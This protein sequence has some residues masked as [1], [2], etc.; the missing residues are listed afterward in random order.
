[1]SD[2]PTLGLPRELAYLVLLFALFVAPKWLQRYRIP[3]AI[4]S[5]ALGVAATF[6]G[7]F[8]GDPTV[9]LLATFGIVALFLFAGLDIDGDELRRN[10][11]TLV[12]HGLI[13][14]L[15]V[16][17]VAAF[18]Q[19]TFR[20]ALRPAILV[21]LAL[22]TPSTGFILSSLSSFGLDDG[23]RFAVK[24]K[25]VAAELLA[26]GALFFVLQT[27]SVTR[28][29]VASFAM[30]G[31]VLLIPLAFRLFAAT[32][33]PHAPRSEFA[34]LLMVALIC[35]YATRRLGV[36]YLVGA[37]VV[38]VAAQRFRARMP[39]MSSE[40]M[41]EA[42]EAFGSVFIPFYFFSAGTH[43]E[44]RE[45]GLAAVGLGLAFVAAF[46]PLRI[47]VTYAH[48]RW[49]LGDSPAAA[50]R[51]AV[52]LVPTLVFTLVLAEILR[53]RFGASH[54]LVGGL[55]VYTIVNTTIPAFVLR[56]S[57]PE[58]ESHLPSGREV[59]EDASRVTAVAAPAPSVE[60]DAQA[61]KV[62][63]GA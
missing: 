38:G 6:G 24:S 31:L 53:D 48:R 4:T 33:A 32:V 58:F 20:L 25:G 11:G 1:M 37:F 34:F 40:K 39:A 10:A 52:S 9:Q 54:L 51:V 22:L 28:F 30:L 45:L 62:S 61:G 49:L 8:V 5:L 36:Y 2:L 12:V 7:W 60:P 3:A 50:K 26:L 46:V 14:I 27:T 29:A 63:H 57:P 15:L 59:R 16:A 43:V 42:L 56:A 47:G 13:W 23:E 17:L 35:S 19:W 18:A 55:I 44:R 41:V 21:A